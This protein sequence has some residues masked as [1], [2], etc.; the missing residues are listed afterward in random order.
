MNDNL[1][2]A[3]ERYPHLIK[4][5]GKINGKDFSEIIMTVY[6]DNDP[7][8]D[9]MSTLIKDNVTEIEVFKDGCIEFKTT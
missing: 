8:A 4:G 3:I 5:S 6:S 2:F 7:K 1:L 9:K